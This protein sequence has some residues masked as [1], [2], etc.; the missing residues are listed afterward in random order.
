ML[1]GIACLTPSAIVAGFCWKT[2]SASL[3]MFF[4]TFASTV[5][6]GELARRQ[7]D[8]RIGV[9]EYLLLQVSVSLSGDFVQSLSL[10]ILLPHL[11]LLTLI[12]LPIFP[13]SLTPGD[14]GRLRTDPRPPSGATS[15]HPTPNRAHNSVYHGALHL[16][17][18]L[19][20]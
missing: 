7:T 9:T 16:E 19:Q 5:A 17:P 2:L 13:L 18:S 10:L 20:V 1:R 15:A 12:T 3:Y 4:A 11:A 8:G 14:T 6:L